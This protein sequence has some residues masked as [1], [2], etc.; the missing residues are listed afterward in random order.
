M[1][2]IET[3]HRR[4]Q[5]FP[6]SQHHVPRHPHLFHPLPQNGTVVD[7]IEAKHPR[8]IHAQR[9]TRALNGGNVR[10]THGDGDS[11]DKSPSERLGFEKLKEWSEWGIGKLKC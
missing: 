4:A 8:C 2:K 7:H 1:I 9:V 10:V 6:P 5:T 11:E 3:P